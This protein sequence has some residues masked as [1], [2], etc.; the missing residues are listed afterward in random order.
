MLKSVFTSRYRDVFHCY[1]DGRSACEGL[2]AKLPCSGDVDLGSKS[3]D[4][5]RKWHLRSTTAPLLHELPHRYHHAITPLCC[6]FDAPLSVFPCCADIVST[7]LSFRDW[8][9]LKRNE[10]L[11]LAVTRFGTRN[12]D[13]RRRCT[14]ALLGV[15]EVV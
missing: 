9:D 3:S 10:P 5:K 4:G 14:E 6:V 2:P 11:S 8:R 12:P 1:D 13:P 15:L 7:R